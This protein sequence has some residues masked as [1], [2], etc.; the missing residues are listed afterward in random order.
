MLIRVILDIGPDGRYVATVESRQDAYSRADTK[1]EAE[2][3]AISLFL[4][5]TARKLRRR[6]WSLGLVFPM[7]VQRV[8][9][10]YL[11]CGCTL[12]GIG[13]KHY[14]A[15]HV[16]I[17]D[18]ITNSVVFGICKIVGCDCVGFKA[19]PTSKDV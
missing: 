13:E 11:I 14:R 19:L 18:I 8:D 12:D 9:L 15:D 10:D 3:H 2:R 7:H 4:E 6:H 5:E 16:V 1:D 17:T